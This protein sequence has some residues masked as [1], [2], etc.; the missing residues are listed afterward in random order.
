M[1]YKKL[2]VESWAYTQKHKKIIIWFGFIPAI[3][4]TTVGIG[5]ISYQFFAL[6]NSYLFNYDGESFLIEVVSFIWEFIQMHMSWTLPLIIV[7]AI[8]FIINLLF[9]T[10]AKA[11]A[12]QTIARNR[13]GQKA[14]VGT[15][16]RYGILSYLPLFEYHLLIKTFAFFSILV[17]MSFVLR[18]L[19]PAIFKF[20]IPFFIIFIFLSFFLTVLF[21]FTD[22]FIVIDGAKVFESMKK[23]SKLVV[24]NWKHTLLIT[25]LMLIIGIRIIIQ[26]IIVFLIPVL[27]IL[28][29]GY[30]ATI[31]LPVTSIIVGGLFGVVALLVSAYLNGIIDIFAYAVWTFAF[32][33]LT[34]EKEVSAREVIS[35][36]G[37][38][39]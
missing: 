10:L 39:A 8:F 12:I 23:S 19:G 6:K 26:A 37:A 18:N 13:N 38:K 32:L 14:G 3:F 28:I 2:I 1:D 24:M 5:Y 9:P 27:V 4:T 36:E 11:G 22:F 15:G 34:K 16:F 31:A 30:I 21:T 17:E 25:V 29:T 33:D 20:L 35:E 7:L